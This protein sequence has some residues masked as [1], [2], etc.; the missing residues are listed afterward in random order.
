MARPKEFD[1]QEVLQKATEV[2]WKK[3]FNGASMQDLVEA[4]GINRASLYD[5]FGDKQRLYLSCLDQYRDVS[6]HTITAETFR[7]LP[8]R[9]RLQ[10]LFRALIDEAVADPDRKGCFVTN[11]AL[12]RASDDL[13]TRRL[14]CR[15]LQFTEDIFREIVQEGQK[16]GEIN[17]TLPAQALAQ[18]WTALLAGFRVVGKVNPDRAALENLLKVALRV[19]D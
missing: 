8:A 9:E 6:H 11:A 13:E 2:F 5:T 15:N 18:Y 17:P 12:E 1:E 4:M 3:G 14:V 10:T 16:A 19:L 7:Q